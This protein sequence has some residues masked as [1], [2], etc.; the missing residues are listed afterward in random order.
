MFNYKLNFL[1]I[2]LIVTLIYLGWESWLLRTP[3]HLAIAGSSD[4]LQGNYYQ[5]SIPPTKGDKY[6]SADYRLWIPDGVQSIS[7]LIL[8]QHGCGDPAAAT[9]LEHANDLQ[10]QALALK[11]HFALLGTKLPTGNQSCDN[12]AL[13]DG[14]SEGAFLKAL[15]ALAHNSRHPELN[16][17]PWALW[18]HSGGAD[19]VAQMLQ[20]YPNRTIA[21]VAMR[22]GGFTFSGT[23]SALLGVP[24]MFAL[25]EKEP[26]ADECLELPKKVFSRYRKAGALWALA[27]EANTGHE[28]SDTRL[29]AIPY[30][31][32]IMTT[33]LPAQGTHLRPIDAA[34]GWLGNIVTYE[35]APVAQY[36]GNPLEAA[37]LPNE[38]TARKWQEYVSTGKISPTLKPAVPTDL[39]VTKIGATEVMLTWHFT[40]DLENGLPSFR[41]YRNK[42]LIETLQGQEHNFGDTPEPSNVTL[43][44]Q[45]EKATPTSSY[46]VAAFNVVGE[47]AS[48]STSS[49]KVSHDPKIKFT[50]SSIL[51]R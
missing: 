40:P 20:K 10:W 34:R 8:K 32:A 44:F 27:V 7:G 1:L 38:E 15:H 47:N 33:R 26:S 2:L 16:E 19:W 21:V 4:L 28:S 23:N 9:G 46:S 49:C 37:W 6:L 14:G 22:C 41:I 24:V 3:Q 17:V 50:S 30:L 51:P 12:W 11:H 5:V 43:E 36:G 48:Q 29:L 42:L 35:I 13:L 25:G 18:G 39:C 45:D 31:D